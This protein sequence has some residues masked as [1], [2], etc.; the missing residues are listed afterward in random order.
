MEV[1][2]LIIRS[3]L[4]YDFNRDLSAGESQRSINDAFGAGTVS[5]ATAKDWFARFR[6]GDFD[7]DDRPRS[8]R[9]SVVD[10]SLLRAAIEANPYQSTRELAERFEVDQKTIFNHLHAMGKVCKFSQWVPHNLSDADRRRRADI[11]AQ[12]LSSSSINTTSWLESIITGDEKWVLYTNVIRRRSWVD[13]GEPAEKQPKAGLHPKKIMLCI[14]WDCKGIIH[15]ELLPPNE[16]IT[17]A[18]YCDQLERLSRAIKET[19][20]NHRT[21]RFLHDN[22]R[23]HT[24]RVTRQKLVDL[25][26]EVL[27]HPPYSPDLAPTDYH[28][29][30]NLTQALANKTFSDRDEIDAW[31]HD[32]FSSKPGTFFS[33]AIKC[34]RGKWQEVL[35][36]DGDYL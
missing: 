23:P 1:S 14:W 32:W 18:V 7:L 20:P 16:T 10:D 31:L 28:L 11:V 4:L 24:A 12:L 9:P 34:L 30:S 25:G 5:K 15:F 27:P 17:A 35:E 33:D 13:K 3:C 8:G 2:K 22:A 19:R 29:F 6:G 26:W 21:V 36:S